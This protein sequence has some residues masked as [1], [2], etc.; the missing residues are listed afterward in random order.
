MS[1]M[2]EGGGTKTHSKAKKWLYAHPEA[3]EQLLQVHSGIRRMLMATRVTPSLPYQI[4]LLGGHLL[5]GLLAGWSMPTRRA[6]KATK[7]A[8][9]WYFGRDR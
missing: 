5:I 7:I 9:S 2:I 8:V 1:Y 3:S 6:F 4:C